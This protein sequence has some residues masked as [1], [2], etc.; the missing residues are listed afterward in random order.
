MSALWREVKLLHRRRAVW[1]EPWWN[2]EYF[3]A[4]QWTSMAVSITSFA[5]LF[6]LHANILVAVVAAFVMIHLSFYATSAYL[7]NR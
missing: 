7:R 6:L 2:D 1:E 4:A 5:A 3:Q